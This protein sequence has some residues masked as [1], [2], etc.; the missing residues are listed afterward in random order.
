MKKEKAGITV[1][2]LA[3]C[4]FY[5]AIFLSLLANPQL[6]APEL[7]PG[8]S[9]LI[10]GLCLLL[11]LVSLLLILF[12][13]GMRKAFLLGNGVLSSVI[14]FTMLVTGKLEMLS[15]ILM[16]IVGVLFFL[17]EKN[18]LAFQSYRPF[19]RKSVLVV[20]DDEVGLKLVQSILLSRGYS[21]LTATTGEKGMQVAKLQQPDLIILDVILP[22]LKGRDVCTKL[23][24]DEKTRDIPVIFLTAK[25]SLDDIH[26]E[27]AAGGL[28]H[29]TKPVQPKT[30]LA[31]IKRIMSQCRS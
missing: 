16:N 26:A 8:H 17:E 18:V 20:D 6:F 15:F 3:F 19:L 5:G 4:L 25:D 30:L 9:S 28:S 27:I 7:F 2:S 22:G 1:V 10:K 31:E 24:D 29:I 12:R 11:C 13:N 21:V 14:F 23:K